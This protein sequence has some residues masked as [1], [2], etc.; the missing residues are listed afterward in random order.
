[1]K[2]VNFKIILPLPLTLISVSPF[3]FQGESDFAG[4]VAEPVQEAEAEE[5]QNHQG[6]AAV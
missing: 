5:K 2:V 4:A 3:L 1:M 6:C